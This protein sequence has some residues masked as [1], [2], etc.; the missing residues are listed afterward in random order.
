LTQLA[1]LISE[2][3]LQKASLSLSIA[4]NIIE[5][6][7]SAGGAHVIKQAAIFAGSE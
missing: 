5:K 2:N 4:A 1:P 6:A 7:Y 3:D